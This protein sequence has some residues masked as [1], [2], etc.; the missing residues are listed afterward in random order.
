MDPYPTILLPVQDDKDFNKYIRD[1]I[2]ASSILDAAQL[3]PAERIVVEQ[4]YWERIQFWESA[5][6]V[7]LH[8]YAQAIEADQ[9]ITQEHKRALFKELAQIVHWHYW[10]A[11]RLGVSTDAKWDFE[12]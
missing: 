11:Q 12:R 8:L 4:L 3:T 1:D 5:S 10:E 2:T 6:K 9:R 7:D